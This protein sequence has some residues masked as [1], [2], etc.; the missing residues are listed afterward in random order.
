MEKGS[1]KLSKLND[2]A[3][4]PKP[5]ERQNVSTCL[6]V[7]CD[8][9]VAALKSNGELNHVDGTQSF[10]SKFVRFFKI[11]NV[12]G[13]GEDIR[14]RDPDRKVISTPDDERLSFLLELADMVDEMRPEKQGQRKNQ[15]TIDTARA[16]S[17]TCRGTV[18]MTKHLLSTTHNYVCLG[19]FSS[20]PIEKMFGK[21]RQGSGGT[22]FINVQQVLQKVTIKKAK[23]CL[24]L[25][26]DTRRN[27]Y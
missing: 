24:D 8:E 25:G 22:Y 26:I 2:V 10:I 3:V 5:I 11:M 21:L 6:K 7:F 17:H 13:L 18:D 14:L 19:Q 23:L 16:F 1:P 12:K 4:A 9:T 20:D 15:L 27:A